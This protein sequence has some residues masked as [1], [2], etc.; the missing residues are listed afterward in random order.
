MHHTVQDK[1]VIDFFIQEYGTQNGEKIGG[2][3][4]LYFACRKK[5]TDEFKLKLQ[6]KKG[7][8]LARQGFEDITSR[9]SFNSFLRCKDFFKAG[10][11]DIIEGEQDFK[12]VIINFIKKEGVVGVVLGFCQKVE[13]LML[14]LG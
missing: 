2:K 6:V 3:I 13:D 7:F 11:I 9:L 8:L 12:L 1:G 5:V 4:A 14:I 10:G